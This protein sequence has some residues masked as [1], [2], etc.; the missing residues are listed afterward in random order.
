MAVGFPKPRFRYDYNLNQEKANFDEFFTDPVRAIP[1]KKANE[2]D[3]ATW[4]IANLGL[5]KRR[6]KDLEL[7]AYILSHFDIIAI[8][9]VNINLN[10]FSK[11]MKILESNNFDMVVTDTAG[12]QERLAVMYSTDLLRPRQLFGELDYNPKGKV[13]GDQYVIPPKK[14]TFT[15]QGNK[16]ETRFYNFNRNPFLSTW[17]VVGRSTTFMLV[18][19]HIYYG[20]DPTD[21]AEFK[22]RIA[23]VYYLANW[24]REQQKAK[25]TP[26]LYESNV[27]LI[28]DMNIPRMKSSDTVYRAL[29]RRGMQPTRYSTEAGTTIQEFNTYDQIV[30]T[31]EELKVTKI[32]NQSAVVVDLDNFIFR[33]LWAERTLAQ[34]KA[35]TKFAISDHR[36]LFV[37]LKV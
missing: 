31:N 35:W 23:E 29:K 11:I 14:Q 19:V 4:N 28:G 18:N 17:E 24:A 26:N 12:N 36:P 32:K 16:I 34:F 2:I 25:K 9:E 30:F 21:S 33:D 22:N 7:I 27:I 37:R 5:Q 13:V 1:Q 10:H 3:L 8:Q 15:F 6:D 20:D